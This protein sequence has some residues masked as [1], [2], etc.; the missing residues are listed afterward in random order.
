[1]NWLSGALAAAED[2]PGLIGPEDR[3][4]TPMWRVAAT[5]VIEQLGETGFD[6]SVDPTVPLHS[7]YLL[8]E[9]DEQAGLRLQRAREMNWQAAG[10]GDGPVR[11]TVSLDFGQGIVIYLPDDDGDGEECQFFTGEGSIRL[12]RAE[13]VFSPRAVSLKTAQEDPPPTAATVRAR[14]GCQT[15]EVRDASARRAG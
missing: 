5:R 11:F 12:L 9:P 3:T 4:L 10:P 13:G 14:T 15:A 1:M 2:I 7:A 6:I 8:S